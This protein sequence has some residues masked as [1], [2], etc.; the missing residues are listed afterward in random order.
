MF[1]DL[2]QFLKRT[3]HPKN[4]IQSLPSHPYADGSS[5]SV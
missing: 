3:F 5:F 4:T 2:T 1:G